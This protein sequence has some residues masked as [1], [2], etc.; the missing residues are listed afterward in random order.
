MYKLRYIVESFSLVV[1][2]PQNLG[3]R[4]SQERHTMFQWGK[5]IVSCKMVITVPAPPMGLRYS[6]IGLVH[7]NKGFLALEFLF[8]KLYKLSQGSRV[9][10]MVYIKSSCHFDSF[11][12]P[13]A[14]PQ[15]GST[16]NAGQPQPRPNPAKQT[17]PVMQK[18]KEISRNAA[19]RNAR[20]KAN[21]Q[22]VW[23][24][25]S[26]TPG[27]PGA[28][29]VAMPPRKPGAALCVMPPKKR[30]KVDVEMNES[31]GNRNPLDEQNRV[32]SLN[33]PRKLTMMKIL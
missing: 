19:I 15:Q 13:S 25:M 12:Q 17:P 22:R 3:P 20:H 33:W 7:I 21:L 32:V 9:L 23:G 11:F 10:I 27:A 2:S 16:Q 14:S 1:Y 8:K 18:P 31:N 24:Q 5:V 29:L 28:A 26:T 6:V 30:S 4:K